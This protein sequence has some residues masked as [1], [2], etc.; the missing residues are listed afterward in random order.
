MSRGDEQEQPFQAHRLDEQIAQLARNPSPSAEARLVYDLRTI[1]R[2]YT[3]SG[4]RVWQRLAERLAQQE[5][6]SSI[7]RLAASNATDSNE[8]PL[9]MQ[10]QLPA[11]SPLTSRQA[12][13]PRQLH[14]FFTLVGAVLVAVALVGSLAAV[15]QLARQK[16]PEKTGAPHEGRT[17]GQII[18]SSPQ[19]PGIN[20]SLAWSANGQRAAEVGSAPY[21]WDATTGQHRVTVQFARADERT[22]GSPAWSPTS[23]LLAIPTNYEVALVDGQTGQIVKSYTFNSKTP[24][25]SVVPANSTGQTSLSSLFPGGYGTLPDSPALAWSP[26]GTQVA[27]AVFSGPT[28]GSEVLIWN[29]QSGQPAVMLAIASNFH[30]SA[31]FW[32]PDGQYI[33]TDML[34]TGPTGD[35][36]Q[37]VVWSVT[38]HQIVFQKAG[39]ASLNNGALW[40]PGSHNLA[41]ITTLPNPQNAVKPPIGLEIW[42]VT[43]G[44]LVKSIPGLNVSAWAWSPDGKEI[45]YAKSYS[46]GIVS[47]AEIA[48]LDVS[49]GQMVSPYKVSSGTI[50]ALAWS[51]N[52]AYIVNSVNQA[53][54][55]TPTVQQSYMVQVWVA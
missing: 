34:N 30:I 43:T 14:R 38:T 20:S 50:G 54:Y 1:S 29:P 7:S 16:P 18:Y 17:P 22:Y 5:M 3:H 19:E 23:D 25:G 2:E 8:R 36:A 48:I 15:F 11:S 9:Y 39:N 46:S 12:K 45:A 21:I 52:G 53:Q 44:Q 31:L 13:P 6:T 27:F 26:Q 4:E 35:A 41:F 10:T 51:P 37:V 24:T 28:A 47:K 32:S 33:A 42:N 40:Q 55:T 49:S